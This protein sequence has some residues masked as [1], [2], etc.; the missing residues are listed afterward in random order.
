[1]LSLLARCPKPTACQHALQQTC[2]GHRHNS[3]FL[4]EEHT[5]W[6]R[7]PPKRVRVSIPSR[8]KDAPCVFVVFFHVSIYR[9]NQLTGEQTSVAAV[10][11]KT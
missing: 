5:A 7:G 10:L 2:D 11:K 1:M 4:A 8:G 9:A 3:A 6:V